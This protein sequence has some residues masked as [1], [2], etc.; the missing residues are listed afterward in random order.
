MNIEE[1]NQLELDEIED[2][3]SEYKL[4]LMQLTKEELTETRKAWGFSGLS[5]L[6]KEEL[7]DELV[8][9]IP[10]ALDSWIYQLDYDVY[11]PLKTLANYDDGFYLLDQSKTGMA[12]TTA[13]HDFGLVC[14]FWKGD[15]IEVYMPHLISSKVREV[16]RNDPEIENK[17]KFNTDINKIS[18]GILIYYGIVEIDDIISK[19]NQLDNYNISKDKYMKVLN[20]YTKTIGM[21]VFHEDK[22][23]LNMVE[24]PELIIE[25]R[26]KR[27]DISTYQVDFD[28]IKYA[29][30]NLYPKP[31]EKVQEFMDFLCDQVDL[32]GKDFQTVMVIIYFELNNMTDI[33]VV[34]S[35]ISDF[36]GLNRTGKTYKEYKKLFKE[37]AWNLHYWTLK[38]RTPADLQSLAPG[39]EIEK[40]KVVSLAA[41]KFKKE[42]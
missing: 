33:D 34:R 6:N 19:I 7:V 20:A 40:D 21:I 5:Q 12:L 23:R 14:A 31:D 26:L 36:V 39:K 10:E 9:L 2:S 29:Y 32:K 22:L 4:M 37:M 3:K 35:N 1:K 42:I 38:A 28:E 8:E 11:L 13:L 30:E 24:S 16:F 27:P 17:I 18:L 25:E 41:Y 15:D